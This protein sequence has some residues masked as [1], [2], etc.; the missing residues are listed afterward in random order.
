MHRTW[1][2]IVAGTLFVLPSLFILIALSWIYVALATCPGWR[3]VLR[4]QAGGGGHRAAGGAAHRQQDAEDTGHA[5]VLW[6]IAHAELRRHRGPED[7]VS[8]GWCWARR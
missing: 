8:R 2:G 1:G 5:P 6:A 3:A 4:H 7:S